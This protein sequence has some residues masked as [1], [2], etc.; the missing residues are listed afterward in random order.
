MLITLLR[1]IA[2]CQ[3]FSEVYLTGVALLIAVRHIF[4][5]IF[6]IIFLYVRDLI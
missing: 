4:N 2:I 3:P 1:H 6:K 5:L